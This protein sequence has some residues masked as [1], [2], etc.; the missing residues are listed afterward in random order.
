MIEEVDEYKDDPKPDRCQA[1][2]AYINIGSYL[3][4]VVLPLPRKVKCG[5][6]VIF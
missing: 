3:S 2:D 4:S 1:I 6:T 5:I